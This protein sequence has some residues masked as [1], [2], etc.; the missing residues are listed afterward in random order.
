M[1]EGQICEEGGGRNPA[2]QR[3][4]RARARRRLCP[5]S[6]WSRFCAPFYE[7]GVNQRLIRENDK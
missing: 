1:S 5:K 7:P 6:E 4:T 2:G 3:Y